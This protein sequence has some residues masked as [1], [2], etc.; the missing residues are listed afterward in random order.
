MDALADVADGDDEGDTVAATRPVIRAVASIR[1]RD[2]IISGKSEAP[3][4]S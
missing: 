1:E 2:S 4:R 3:H